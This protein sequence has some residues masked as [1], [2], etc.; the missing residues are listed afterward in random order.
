MD[1]SNGTT[2]PKDVWKTLPTEII[3]AYGHWVQEQVEMGWDAYLFSFMFDHLPGPVDAKIQQMHR[4]IMVLYGKLVG[5]F[6]RKP[7]SVSSAHLL[8]KGVFFPDV[9]CF[10]HSSLPQNGSVNKGVHMHGVVL[11]TREGRLKIGLDQHF[12]EHQNL[13]QTSRMYRIH[14]EPIRFDACYV[15]DYGGKAIKNSRFSTDH[16]LVLPKSPSELAKETRPADPA[17]RKMQD[18]QSR[19]NVSDEVA[20][21]QMRL[22]RPRG[23]PN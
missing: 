11:A 9:P 2:L 8:P 15:T 21:E 1:D 19:Y 6:V 7:R 5:W 13:Y 18:I 12:R 4:E 16:I 3:Q 14:V 10:R 22:D 23:R 17:A 20:A